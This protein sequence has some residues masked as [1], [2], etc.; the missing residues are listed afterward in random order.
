MH[1]GHSNAA[2]CVDVCRIVFCVDILHEWACSWNVA[3]GEWLLQAAA[4]SGLG[5]QVTLKFATGHAAKAW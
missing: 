1:D 4:A 5:R 3:Q 2:A